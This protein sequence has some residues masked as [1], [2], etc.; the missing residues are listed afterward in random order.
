MD[1]THTDKLNLNGSHTLANFSFASDGSGGTI[2]YDPPVSMPSSQDTPN[3]TSTGTS[4]PPSIGTGKMLELTASDPGGA[5]F[6]GSAGKLILDGVAPAGHALDFTGPVTGSGGG[7]SSIFRASRSMHKPRLAMRRTTI[8][9]AVHCRSR[10][11]PQCQYR[12][13]GQLY[14][15]VFCRRER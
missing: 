2:V 12:A 10:T 4:G 13:P 1:G 11:A 15:V 9:R 5:A 14:G 6:T 8:R 3:A 7:T